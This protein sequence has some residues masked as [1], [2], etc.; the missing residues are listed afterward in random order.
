MG[1][2][3]TH[4]SIAFPDVARSLKQMAEQDQAMR[5]QSERDDSW[6]ETVDEGNTEKLRSTMA[7]IGW[8]TISKVGREAS[9]AAWLIAQHADHDVTFQT[10]CLEAM[11]A[12]PMPEVEAENL[13]Y[14]WD[15]VLVNQGLPQKYGTQFR[16]IDGEHVLAT[17]IEDEA[18][19]DAERA[20]LGLAPLSEQ[21]DLMYEKYPLTGD[22]PANDE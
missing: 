1:F 2:E 15:R 5:A 12:V 16:Q 4:E 6:D 3:D 10:S 22:K 9:E 11:R 19:V 8:P 7:N 14:L 18:S 17:P 20:A 21:F 13:A